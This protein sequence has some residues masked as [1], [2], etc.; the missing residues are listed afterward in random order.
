MVSLRLCKNCDA[1]L[2]KEH[3]VLVHDITGSTYCD[4]ENIDSIVEAK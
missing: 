3:G 1:P 2:D 4:P